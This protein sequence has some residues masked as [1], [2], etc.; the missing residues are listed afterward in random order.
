MNMNIKAKLRF[1]VTDRPELANVIIDR[2]LVL[3]FGMPTSMR[4]NKLRWDS[5]FIT[6]NFFGDNGFITHGCYETSG[7]FGTLATLNDL[8][9]LPI[10]REI[11][12][13]GKTTTI[14]EESFQALKEQFR[15]DES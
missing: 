4:E 7:D 8:Y 5:R 15:G 10:K 12:I 2:L 3:G 9:D 13:D 1:D 6:T 14:S 11:T